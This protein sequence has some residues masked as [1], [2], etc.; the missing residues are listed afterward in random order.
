MPS[1]RYV[2]SLIFLSLLVDRGAMGSRLFP[3]GTSLCLL[4]HMYASNDA[5]M[6]SHWVTA[7]RRTVLPDRFCWVMLESTIVGSY[8]VLYFSSLNPQVDVIPGSNLCSLA[9]QSFSLLLV[10]VI[11]PHQ[12]TV[13]P[14]GLMAV[15]LNWVVTDPS[16][17]RC[18][19][20][21]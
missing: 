11:P 3:D 10:E 5:P 20:K 9:E 19:P 18:F 21:C 15:C 2:C 14:R 7:R 12:T 1:R 13:R 8:G 6:V 16:E 17:C 4:D